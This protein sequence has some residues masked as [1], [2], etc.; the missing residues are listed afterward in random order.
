MCRTVLGVAP[1]LGT[2]PDGVSGILSGA[3][4]KQA[5]PAGGKFRPRRVSLAIPL[6]HGDI[7]VVE[8]IRDLA[9]RKRNGE[10]KGRWNL[11]LRAGNSVLANAQNIR[12]FRQCHF[13]PF[14]HNV[15][16]CCLVCLVPEV[17]PAGRGRH[18][19]DVRPGLPSAPSS[20]RAL[21]VG[22]SRA[23]GPSG[24]LRGVSGPHP[25]TALDPR[26]DPRFVPSTHGHF[27]SQQHPDLIHHQLIIP[28]KCPR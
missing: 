21:A 25:Y 10:R 5:V 19:R 18:S 28:I 1:Q 3:R 24:H 9:R 2:Y 6:K 16:W 22:R 26:P 13:Q 15:P 11:G 8:F 23:A 27:R 14:S 17:Y 7:I 4:T 20:A 12:R